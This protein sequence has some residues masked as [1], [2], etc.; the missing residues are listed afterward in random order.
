MPADM[1]RLLVVIAHPDDESFGIGGTMARLRRA[2]WPVTL[3]C[4]T[5]GEVGEI[6]DPMLATP[7]TLG[8]VR[9]RELREA[10]AVLGVEDVRFLDFRDS[11]MAGTPE[12]ADPRALCNAAPAAAVEAIA[13]QMRDVRPSLVITWD[14]SGGY[15][16][17]DHLAVHRHATAA[18]Q[19]EAARLDG[20]RALYYM[21]L[22][23]HL[24]EQM[25]A[26]LRS[27]G[28]QFGSDDLREAAR[29][30]PRLSVTTEIDVSGLEELKVESGRK[31]ATQLPPDMP[32]DRLSPELRR[33]FLSVEYF[34]RVV[35]HWHDG[36]PIEHE[37]VPAAGSGGA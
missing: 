31:H 23:V 9:E 7:E 18:F 20:P 33:A 22:P 27:Q 12:N 34:H 17:P 29:D 5:R 19:R 30:L 36:D 21:A 2:G 14:P 6:S 35:P 37:F 8:Q 26:E 1:Q 10:C 24:F 25:E 15:G 4:A 3:L 16:H 13:A 28:I 11:G 32:F